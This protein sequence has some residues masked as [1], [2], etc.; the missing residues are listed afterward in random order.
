M[1][2]NIQP[3]FLFS[4]CCHI[5]CCAMKRCTAYPHPSSAVSGR[6]MKPNGLS[7]RQSLRSCASRAL[8]TPLHAARLHKR[9]VVLSAVHTR[10]ASA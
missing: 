2:I 10:T 9:A 1:Y 8:A 3:L 6:A 7:L 4:C 5:A